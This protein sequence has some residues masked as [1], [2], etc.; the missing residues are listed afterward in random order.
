M[1]RLPAPRSISPQAQAAVD[2]AEPQPGIYPALTDTEGWR[3]HIAEY[4]A[5]LAEM[6]RWAPVDEGVT[7][8]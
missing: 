8:R 7:S 2:A 6:M 5:T 4:D 1:S 3:R